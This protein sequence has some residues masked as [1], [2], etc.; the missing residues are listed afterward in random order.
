MKKFFL[1]FLLLCLSLGALAQDTARA[2]RAADATID[3]RLGDDR[4]AQWVK[5]KKVTVNADKSIY[6]WYQINPGEIAFLDRPCV[7]A[8]ESDAKTIKDIKGFM[9]ANAGIPDCL[10]SPELCQFISRGDAL[11]ILEDELDI[12]THD[13]ILF[14]WKRETEGEFLSSLDGFYIWR[15][16]I[17][18]DAESNLTRV[19]DVHASTG[20]IIQDKK[21]EVEDVQID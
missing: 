4:A 15:I 13:N 9:I 6:V 7:V 3:V 17:D 16:E 14:T 11:E 18:I 19:I 8:F 21:W 12:K 1:P 20:E 5:F 10:E 2:H